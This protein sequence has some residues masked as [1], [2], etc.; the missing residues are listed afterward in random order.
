ML[1]N[2][3]KTIYVQGLHLTVYNVVI[4]VYFVQF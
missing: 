1:C 3:I 4:L 2:K